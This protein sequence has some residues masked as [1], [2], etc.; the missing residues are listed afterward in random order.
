MVLFMAL[1]FIG[2][3]TGEDLFLT[4]SLILF[5]IYFLWIYAWAKKQTGP[6]IGLLIA[7]IITFI[8]FYNFPELIW[9]P[10]LLF[11]WSVFGKELLERV[12]KSK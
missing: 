8:L 12:P 7:I 1:D 9:V 6:A 11:L 4:I 10:L 3:L 5:V 2:G